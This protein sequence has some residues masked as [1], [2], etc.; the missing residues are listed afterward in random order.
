MVLKTI[1]VVVSYL[2]KRP[3]TRMVPRKEESPRSDRTR[4]RHILLMDKCTGCSMCQQ[5]CPAN[6]IDMVKV[7]GSWPQNKLGR[8]PRIDE[9]KCTFCGLC[10]EYCPFSALVMTDITGFEL[11]TKDKS[12]TFYIPQMLASVSERPNYRITFTKDLFTHLKQKESWVGV[13]KISKAVA[14]TE[15]QQG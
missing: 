4:G 15:K 3:Y 9:H 14:E 2:M 6:A 8:F 7:E 12:K 11:T 10:V 1:S 5:V 13:Q